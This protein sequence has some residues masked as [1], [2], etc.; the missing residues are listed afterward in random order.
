MYS[1]DQKLEELESR[2]RSIIARLEQVEGDDQLQQVMAEAYAVRD[3]AFALEPQ[4]TTGA[5]ALARI[6]RQATEDPN[7]FEVQAL[8]RFLSVAA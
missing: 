6:A 7:S 3:Q 4:T 8:D 1:A 5:A 2:H